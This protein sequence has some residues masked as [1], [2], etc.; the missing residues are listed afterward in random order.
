MANITYLLGA[1]ASYN[2]CPVWKEQGEK[3]VELAT[4]YQSNTD[5]NTFKNPYTENQS[6]FLLWDIGYFGI[7]AIK[8]NTIDAYAR[9]LSFSKSIDE[10]DRLKLAISV[11][12]TLW[13]L[14]DDLEIRRKERFTDIIDRRYITLLA[15]LLE[16]KNELNPILPSN[17]NIISWNYDLQFEFA[18]KAFCEDGRNWSDIRRTLSFTSE[19]K[20]SLQICHLNGYHGFYFGGRGETDFLDR[21]KDKNTTKDILDSISFIV[22]SHFESKIK[23]Y[24]HINYAWDN[25]SDDISISTRKRAKKIFSETDVLIIIG[26]SFPPFNKEIDRD[27]FSALRKNNLEIIYQDPNASGNFLNKLVDT[28]NLKVTYLTEKKDHFYFPY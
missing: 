18:Y 23:F 5:F 25:D 17:I 19:N 9:K 16:N 28:A 27:L 22:K 3:M 7:K 13:Q 20:D 26:Y 8:Y 21:S 11:F 10:L 14:S 4:T 24:N 15:G 12:F 6:E 2:A 1:G